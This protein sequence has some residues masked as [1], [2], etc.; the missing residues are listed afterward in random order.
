VLACVLVVVLLIASAVSINIAYM[1]HTRAELRAATDAATRAAGEALSRTDDE[2][3]ARQA[4]KDAGLKN[5]VA[6][7]P[8]V[9]E[10]SD[11]IFGNAIEEESGKWLF[12]AGATPYNSVQVNG[13]RLGSSSSGEVMLFFGGILGNASFAPK[14]QAAVVKG[15][16]VERDFAV[17]VDR[18]GSMNESASGGGTKWEALR[19]A[20]TGFTSALDATLD[21]EQVG[22]A[23]Y[24]SSSSLDQ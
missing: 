17:V 10:D 11:I 23:S 12:D 5:T 13:G 24:S 22:L 1:Q 21:E 18:S 16:F 14:S 4:A 2:A 8:F 15:T 7:V 19:T 6:G 9:V 3:I 20:L